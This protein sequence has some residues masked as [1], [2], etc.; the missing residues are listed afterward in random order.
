MT[1]V[2]RLFQVYLLSICGWAT[3]SDFMHQ[4]LKGKFSETKTQAEN[5]EDSFTGEFNRGDQELSIQ[6]FRIEDAA[7]GE[8]RSKIQL[9]NLKNLYS[10]R[11]NPYD[12]EITNL[13]TCDAKMQPQEIKVKVFGRTANALCGG[14]AARRVFGAC[15]RQEAKYWACQ[16]SV[17]VPERK[18]AIDIRLFEPAKNFK[19]G[20]HLATAIEAVFLRPVL[21]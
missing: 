11:R 2:I 13:L 3:P 14:A 5:S 9:A 15:T 21:K 20:R 12:G 16:V 18:L 1:L 10:D 8:E 6:A 7:V 17:Y 19:S 4:Y